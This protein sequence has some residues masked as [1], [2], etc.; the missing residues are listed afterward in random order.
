[1]NVAELK[2]E[3]DKYPDHFAIVFGDSLDWVTINHVVEDISQTGGVVV[4]RSH[5]PE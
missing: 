4:L 3:L 5:E 2:T 1:M